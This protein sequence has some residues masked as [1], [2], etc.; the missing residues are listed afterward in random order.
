MPE[1]LR[2]CTFGLHVMPISLKKHHLGITLRK[3]LHLQENSPR[4]RLLV[5]SYILPSSA[6]LRL[7][8]SIFECVYMTEHLHR[9]VGTTESDWV[10][11]VIQ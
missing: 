2:I 4:C 11:A 7:P 8:D 1:F 10:G 3:T 9:Q 6:R 5:K